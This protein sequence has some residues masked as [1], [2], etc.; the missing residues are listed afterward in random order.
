MESMG[1]LSKF[2]SGRKDVLLEAAEK[3]HFSPAP[4]GT[5]CGGSVGMTGAGVVHHMG[6]VQV[7]FCP[8]PGQPESTKHVELLST[9]ACFGGNEQ[10]KNSEEKTQTKKGNVSVL[11]PRIPA[12]HY[13]RPAGAT[14]HVERKCCRAA[15]RS[16][17]AAAITSIRHNMP[18]AS[19]AGRLRTAASP[20]RQW[21]P[22]PERTRLPPRRGLRI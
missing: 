9:S 20:P 12:P 4:V 19:R 7:M 1:L 11:T 13:V 18:R 8:P 2:A 15:P 16:C 22:N 14:T 5:Y 21:A 3:T 10:E 6:R 17:Q